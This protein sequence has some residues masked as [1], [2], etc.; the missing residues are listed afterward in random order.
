MGPSKLQFRTGRN[1]RHG[2]VATHQWREIGYGE[3]LTTWTTRVSPSLTSTV[4]PG[5]CW[6]AV[7]TTLFMQSC[8]IPMPPTWFVFKHARAGRH[9]KVTTGNIGVSENDDKPHPRHCRTPDRGLHRRCAPQPPRSPSPCRRPE[10]AARAA[11]WMHLRAPWISLASSWLLS[12]VAI[13]T[14][15]CKVHE[16]HAKQQLPRLASS[17]IHE[18]PSCRPE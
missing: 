14:T 5:S 2:L 11:R 8:E 12:P 3:P 9:C 1:H 13:Q 6:F 10:S 15:V 7:Y 16:L 18:W 17:F 4:G